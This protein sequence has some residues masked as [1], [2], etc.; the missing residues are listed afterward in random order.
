MSVSCL[1]LCSERK[2]RHQDSPRALSAFLRHGLN[3]ASH[4]RGQDPCTTI[5][6][7]RGRHLP[8]DHE[9][10]LNTESQGDVTFDHIAVTHQTLHGCS[11]RHQ[12]RLEAAACVPW[13]GGGHGRSRESSQHL[14]PAGCEEDVHLLIQFNVTNDHRATGG[15]A[16]DRHKPML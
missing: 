5:L 13:L 4:C 2:Y 10:L 6:T 7:Y 11:A 9:F 15:T 1:P 12:A 3:L 8:D 14:L 16:V